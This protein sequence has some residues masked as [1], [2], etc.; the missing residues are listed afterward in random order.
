MTDNIV[1]LPNSGMSPLEPYYINDYANLEKAYNSP[2]STPEKLAVKCV[3]SL[4]YPPDNATEEELREAMLH[5]FR[6]IKEA[7][8]S[9]T[10][11]TKHYME[12]DCGECV[13]MGDL[14]TWDECQGESF[15]PSVSDKEK[16]DG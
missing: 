1:H 5:N 2:D 13:R 9:V 10:R 3:N 6:F 14:C 16:D 4:F 15:E 7:C 8:E 11:P 12:K